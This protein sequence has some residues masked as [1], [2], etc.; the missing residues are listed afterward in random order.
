M[1]KPETGQSL[2]STPPLDML[3]AGPDNPDIKRRLLEL[4][5]RQ[6]AAQ[7]AL[8]E[9]QTA[10]ADLTLRDAR[11]KDEKKA[12]DERREEL[13]RKE[14]AENHLRK[15]RMDLAVQS[16]CTHLH[17]D[18]GKSTLSA[19]RHWDQRLTINCAICQL[20]QTGTQ[21][22]LVRKYGS[23]FPRQDNI[24]GVMAPGSYVSN[25]AIVGG[26]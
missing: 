13:I 12:E 21:A 24:G 25:G 1:A 5:E 16:N 2:P 4:Q 8:L 6:L 18:S 17:P 7:V 10:V 20:N 11:I 9:K 26:Q 14:G 15:M 22:E 3:L 19:V 23:L